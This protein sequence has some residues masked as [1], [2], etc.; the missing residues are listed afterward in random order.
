M[1]FMRFSVCVNQGSTLEPR[2][3]LTADALG[4]KAAAEAGSN[5]GGIEECDGIATRYRQAIRQEFFE[6]SPRQ[7][8]IRYKSGKHK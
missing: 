6:R 5:C 1:R 2:T 8:W 3:T 7:V 4:A